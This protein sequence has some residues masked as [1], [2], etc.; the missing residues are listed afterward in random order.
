MINFH[1]LSTQTITQLDTCDGRDNYIDF[2]T[3]VM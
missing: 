3:L 1:F 2:K